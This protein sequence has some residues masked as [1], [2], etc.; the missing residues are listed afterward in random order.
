MQ[1]AGNFIYLE[2]TM[3]K[4]EADEEEDDDDDDDEDRGLTQIRLIFPVQ[5]VY[6]NP[7]LIDPKSE[8]FGFY[9][10]KNFYTF[11]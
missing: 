8:V 11:R 10:E 3:P 6:K 4:K 5:A 2:F 7:L 1:P 9:G